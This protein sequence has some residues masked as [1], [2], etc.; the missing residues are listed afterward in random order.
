MLI[1]FSFFGV[2]NAQGKLQGLVL[3]A[4][5]GQPISDIMVDLR[6]GIRF[7]STKT[8]SLGAYSTIE[9][10]PGVYDVSFVKIGYSCYINNVAIHSNSFQWFDVRIEYYE[11]I[12]CAT[13]Q[14]LEPLIRPWE[15]SSVTHF[16]STD[17][18]RFPFR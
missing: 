2:L 17:L 18:R 5:T 8:D 4:D 7:F 14:Y 10:D 16:M 1:F 6:K 9:L 12:N 15:L 3:D 11:G 13:A